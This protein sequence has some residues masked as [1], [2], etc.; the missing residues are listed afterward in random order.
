METTDNKKITVTIGIPAHNEEANIKNLLNSILS[1][2]RDNFE[3]EKIIVIS[4]GSTD[5]TEKRVLEIN[6]DKIKIIADGKRLSK[7]MRI[8]QIFSEADS[9]IVVI[10]DADIKLEDDSVLDNLIK[11]FL[12]DSEIMLVSGK[13]EPLTPVNFTQKVVYFGIK[14]WDEIKEK[15]G[16]M[17]YFCEGP[18]RAFRKNLYKEIKFPPTSADDVYPYLFSVEKGYKFHYADKAIACHKLPSTYADYVKQMK[19]YLKSGNIHEKNFGKDFI[20]KHYTVTF[21]MKVKVLLKNLFINPFWTSSYLI[22]I[23]KPKIISLFYG[24]K[25]INGSSLW[26]VIKSTK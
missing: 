11:P 2:R 15:S 7:P 23:A 13:S 5:S 3:L 14:I 26:E 8:N 9:D 6:S 19:R 12:N 18:I 10:F 1:Q 24:R 20:R 21:S 4:D 17:M 22:F 25:N 16:S